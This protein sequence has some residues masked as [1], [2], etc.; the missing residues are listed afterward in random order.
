MKSKLLVLLAIIGSWFSLNTLAQQN[1]DVLNIFSTPKKNIQITSTG[2]DHLFTTLAL[3]GLHNTADYPIDEH[4]QNFYSFLEE[5]KLQF[6]NNNYNNAALI[7]TTLQEEYLVSYAPYSLFIEIFTAKQFNS[8]TGTALFALALDY[9]NIPYQI[10]E[11]PQYVYLTAYPNDPNDTEVIFESTAANLD[12]PGFVYRRSDDYKQF[13]LSNNLISEEEANDAHF[14]DPHFSIDTII[15]LEQLTAIPYYHHFVKHLAT[16]ETE[17]AMHE[18]E[19]A[20]AINESPYMLQWLKIIILTILYDKE[21]K[22]NTKTYC[23][24]L[25]KFKQY[26]WDMD[27]VE[28]EVVS[29]SAGRAQDLLALENGDSLVRAYLNCLKSSLESTDLAKELDQKIY[30]ILAESYYK[31]ND[32]DKALD[33]LHRSFEPGV[34]RQQAYIKNC[35]INKFKNIDDSKQGLD[36]L[37]KYEA[38]F[39]FINNDREVKS[40][41]AYFLMKGAYTHFK[42]KE[43]EDG[44]NSLNVFKTTFQPGD[45]ALYHKKPIAS[46]FA[47]AVYFYAVNRQFDKAKEWVNQGLQYAPESEELLQMQAKLK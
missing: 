23:A 44:L 47:S 31:A 32:F 26:N 35:L 30:L 37:K 20:V 13:L 7:Y 29:L 24:Y 39:P 11:T 36:S 18:L 38:I 1:S 8:I 6:T 10:R 12:A 27:N 40:H 2:G 5:L 41:K 46:A 25:S 34:E 3:I 9:Y 17:Y 21:N 28:A 33:Y 15:S 22:H 14:R 19:K 43:I 4:Q 42:Q 45:E 16:N